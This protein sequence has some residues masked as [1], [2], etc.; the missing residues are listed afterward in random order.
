MKT[1]PDDKERDFT[2]LLD[3]ESKTTFY[4]DFYQRLQGCFHIAFQNIYSFIA[5]RVSFQSE[6]KSKLKKLKK[7]KIQNFLYFFGMMLF[8]NTTCDV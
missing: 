5:I 1:F 6:K 7:Q 3:D 2:L 8:C 4:V